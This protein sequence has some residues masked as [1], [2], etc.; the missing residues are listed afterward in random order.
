MSRWD[1]WKAQE[2]ANDFAA[3][4]V[5]AALRER[6]SRP[7]LDAKRWAGVAAA[8]AGAVLVA[9]V[10]W[11]SWVQLR[12]MPTRA[13]PPTPTTTAAPR[14][15]Q[16]DPQLLTGQ[17][18][19]K[20]ATLAAV[21]AEQRR[22]QDIRTKLQATRRVAPPAGPD[23]GYNP[24]SPHCDCMPGDPLCSCLGAPGPGQ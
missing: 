13:A 19:A 15:A 5:T 24:I 20:E 10:A 6:G 18:A 3:R 14:S 8:A 22:L 7:R 11:G 2:P 4:T 21:A 12:G 16:L 23:A 9:G 1:P 17:E